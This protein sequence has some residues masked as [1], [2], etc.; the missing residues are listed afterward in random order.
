MRRSAW[1][2]YP[3]VATIAMVAYYLLGNNSFVFNLIGLSSPI[4][5]LIAVRIHKPDH[6]WAWYLIA[7]GQFVFIAGDVASYNYLRLADVWPILFPLDYSLNPSGDVPFPSIA[8]GLYLA[9]YPCLIAG[10]TLM[11]RARTPGGD[12][13]G[14]LDSLMVAIGVGT[15]SWVLLISP[16]IAFDDLS[17]ATKVTAMAYPVMDLLLAGAV[18][19]LAVGAGRRPPAF[20]LMILAIG[21][22]FVTDA[23]YGWFG[24]YTV[25][26]YQPGSGWLEIGWMAFYVLLGMAALHPSMRELVEPAG[27]ASWKIT[28]PRLALLA[29]A[30]LVAP[31]V[32]AIQVL[33]GEDRDFMVLVG[34]TIV[35]FGLVVA[36]MWG[37]TRTQQAFAA[38]EKAL[39]EAGA[40]L[41]T[42]AGRESLHRAA[43][44]A[45]CDL[46]GVDAAV[47]VCE[48]TDAGDFVVAASSGGEDAL[49]ATF[50]LDML[51]EW[52]RE[53]LLSHDAYEV[54]LSE[55][56]LAKPLGLGWSPDGSSFVAPLF[57]REQMSGLL[58]VAT[59]EGLSR[60]AVDSLTALST[61]VALA[62]ESAALTEDLLLQQS[63]A[64]FASLVKNSSDVVTVLEPDTTVRYASPSAKR[65]LGTEPSLLE[66]TR[67]VDLV[68]AE[69]RTRVVTFLTSGGE[70]EGSTG[71]MEFRIRHADGTYLFVETL[72]T[73]LLHD[74]NVEGIVLNTRDIT[75][76]KTF[77][78][79]LSHQAFHD[80]I[81][82]L[83]NRALFRDRVLHALERQERDHRPVAVLF[84]D[85]DDF[86]TINDSMGHAAGDELLRGVGDRVRD[87][88]RASDT[89]ARLGGD[90]FGVLLEEGGD[91][92]HAAEVAQRILEDLHAPFAIDDKEVFARASIG[93][94]I[95]DGDHAGEEGAEELLRNA[96]VAMYMAKE[97]GKG[98]YQVFESA[99][100]DTAL[101][102]LELKADLQRALEHDEFI[103]HFQPVIELESGSVSGVEA[104]VRWQHPV[105]GLVPPLEFIPLAEE[106][107]LIAPLG[108]WVL[109]EACLTAKALQE[110][111]APSLHIAVNLSAR[112]LQRAEIIDEVRQVLDETMLDPGKLILEITETVMMQ[113]MELSISRLT[114]LKELGVQLAIDDFGTGY[115]S[116]NYV[117]RFPVDI[118]KVDKS[119]IDGVGD[120]GE[121]SALTAAVIE[122][123]GILNLKPVAEGIERADQLERLL[124]LN[125]DLGQGFLF[126]KPL[127]PDELRTLLAERQ[128]L[129]RDADAMASDSPA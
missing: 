66:G 2:V 45:A 61:Q 11:I 28:F 129:A 101:K 12:R 71:L 21:A 92:L 7:L 70:G 15:L 41:V 69:D 103:L 35:L 74:P 102:R 62:L 9:V 43:I 51:A 123:A 34:A 17:L 113:D 68:H 37:L 1:L 5:I 10:I 8:D 65:V 87:A 98:R 121:S 57:L 117:R 3:I 100:H 109:R 118:L 119:F 63:E 110:T 4:L 120:G 38:R 42:A 96:D 108:R 89:A 76:R 6:P 99:M 18:I 30:S 20:R 85:L 124:E 122:L 32:L 26:G 111:V 33:R 81:T 29:G 60:N 23:I 48:R 47:R 36:R 106:T 83:A 78:E 91:G 58:V 86:K 22:L 40:E 49:G 64:R 107:G 115:S 19:R 126:A 104:L 82:G 112:Q 52:K 55:S 105:R 46:V 24:L 53:L 128:A 77:E 67:L 73:S 94:A 125:C 27:E 50:A 75:E 44:D 16:Y 95:T 14:L 127:P 79:Q 39:R 54:P 56:G 80:S 90:E 25:A 88:L 72:R 59:L 93:I 97:R 31:I 114:Q 84:M 13:A 116:L